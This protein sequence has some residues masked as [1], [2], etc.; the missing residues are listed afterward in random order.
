MIKLLSCLFPFMTRWDWCL[1][2]VLFY[3]FCVCPGSLGEGT[4]GSLARGGGHSITWDRWQ[5][6]GSPEAVQEGSDE[7]QADQAR[8]RGPLH[9]CLHGS[10]PPRHRHQVCQHGSADNNCDLYTEK[11]WPTGEGFIRGF[12]WLS[13]LITYM[14]ETKIMWWW[15]LCVVNGVCK[16]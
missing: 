13:R 6:P 5:Q 14:S 2:T 12:F 11:T 16:Y 9:G 3:S 8:E 10:T 7:L 1:V 4:Q 15:D